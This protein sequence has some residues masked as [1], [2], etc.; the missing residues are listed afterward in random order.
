MLNRRLIILFAVFV[1]AF[2]ALGMRLFHLQVTESEHWKEEM[3]SYV[4]RHN[5]IETARGAILD[6]TGKRLAYDNA[7]Y[8][9][10]IDYRA[11]NL[12]DRWLA[13][14][15]REKLKG[16]TF[17]DRA[18][19]FRRL[20]ETKAEIAAKVERIPEEIAARCDTSALSELTD[21][22]SPKERVFARFEQIRQLIVQLRQNKWSRSYNAMEDQMRAAGGE[23]MDEAAFN[24]P[25][26]EE[27]IEHTIIPNIPDAEA[28]VFRQHPEDFPGIVVVDSRVR[29]YP[30]QTVAC[31]LLGTL[32]SVDGPTQRKRRFVLPNLLSDNDAG[33]LGG[34]LQ[35][36]R[37]GESGLERVLESEL[38]GTRGVRLVETGV[39]GDGT[40]ATV[41]RRIEPMLG[42]SVRTTLDIS[43]QADLEA[44]I[45]DP[46]RG[47]AKG[48][49]GKD[50][51]VAV[52]VLSM[53][54]QVLAMM[55]TPGY[56]P[57]KIDDERVKLGQAKYE[58][59][60]ANRALEGFRPGSTIKP[61][62]AAA[63][64]T[65]GVITPETSVTCV[66]HMFAGRPTIFKCA[67]VHGTVSLDAAIAESCNI[68]F[69]NAGDRLGVEKLVSW[70]HGYGFGK[71][72]GFE[73]PDSNGIVKPDFD[74]R[75]AD[76]LRNEARFM[77]IGEGP[78]DTTPLQL[79]SAYATL[80]R[81]G[82]RIAP[83]ILVD[84][85]PAV[86]QPFTLSAAT[87]AAVKHGMRGV[88][89]NGTGKRVFKDMQ[90]A[91]GGKTGTA[92]VT[93]KPVFD[94][95]GNPVFNVDKPLTN[96]DGTPRLDDDK[97]PMY[98]RVYER[99]THAWFVGYAPAEEP[100]FVVVA[101]KEF[102]G[103]GGSQAAP[104]V[105]EAFLQLER[106]GYLKPLDVPAEA[107]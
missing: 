13:S 85:P 60:L 70:F 32:R 82:Q 96:R 79:A 90:L 29:V 8:D 52:V 65:E 44:A 47:F 17:P 59:P 71:E 22:P 87:L 14:L 83:R 4:H 99:G 39:S 102:G 76:T 48:Q 88:I 81:G 31:H 43:L 74:S 95:Q 63:G 25:L 35:G 61:L 24:E 68:Y 91:V 53:D 80:L 46:A 105:K 49:D 23:A 51:V 58:R 16:E 89:L 92:D 56:D 5:K 69:Y 30:Y 97:K 34:Y 72:S 26:K 42:K 2:C 50:H 101:V 104:M 55:S 75:D 84:T 41:E 10:A 6:R 93:N 7:C 28:F 100:K 18:T 77:G 57:N 20:V 15:A 64:L 1:F 19:R 40:D 98:E 3:R 66:G 11:M 94:E 37:M 27:H 54:G 38:R 21:D 67:E 62:V 12:D 45:K 86:S 73:L 36:D 107:P 9:L 33:D 103:H 106:H 78:I